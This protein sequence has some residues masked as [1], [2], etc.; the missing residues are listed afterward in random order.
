MLMVNALAGCGKTTTGLWGLGD[1]VKKGV[2]ITQE[3]KA[4]V[5][6]MRR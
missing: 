4:I 3:Q 1:R 2:I 6:E 5:E